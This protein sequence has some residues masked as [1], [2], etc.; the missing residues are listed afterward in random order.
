L[1][2]SILLRLL[3]IVVCFYCCK[4]NLHIWFV[5]LCSVFK[6]LR[7]YLAATFISYQ[8]FNLMSTLFFKSFKVFFCSA[9]SFLSATTSLVYQV[10]CY[11]STTFFPIFQVFFKPEVLFYCRHPALVTL[12]LRHVI[13]YQDSWL[14]SI[15]ICIFFEL[16]F[17]T[18]CSLLSIHYCSVLEELQAIFDLILNF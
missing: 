15:K 8:I 17:V 10:V 7:C 3:K 6:G 4:N 14:R 18:D 2:A 11:L 9:L 16:F 1:F 13:I 5:L 12:A